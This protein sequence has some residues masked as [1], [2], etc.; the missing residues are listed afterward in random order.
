ML[1][2]FRASVP[3]ECGICGFWF[4]AYLRAARPVCVYCARGDPIE[5]PEA[6]MTALEKVAELQATLERVDGHAVDT[7]PLEDFSF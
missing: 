5:V 1:G 7:R 6:T 4:D 3:V 2:P